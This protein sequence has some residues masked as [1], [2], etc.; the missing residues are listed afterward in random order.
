MIKRLASI[1]TFW[2]RLGYG[3]HPSPPRYRKL[4]IILVIIWRR[5][6][7]LGVP[8][9]GVVAPD[10]YLSTI[11]SK[12][13]FPVPSPCRLKGC[14]VPGAPQ[15]GSLFPLKSQTEL[16]HRHLRFLCSTAA[17]LDGR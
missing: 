16:S 7:A 8:S 9:L 4:V 15:R 6:C 12:G 3:A 17:P 13:I 10:N 11:R 2:V 5:P 1:K 14:L